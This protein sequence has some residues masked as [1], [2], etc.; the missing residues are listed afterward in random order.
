MDAGFEALIKQ[1]T[2]A[3]CR[4]DGQGV[5]ACFTGDGVYHDVFYGSF[6]GADIID[7][8]EAYFHR[9]GTDFRWD[10]HDPVALEGV[11]YARYVFS[12]ASKLE[13]HEGR[14]ACFE[15]VAICRLQDGLITDYRE[16]ANA[17]TG[18]SLIGFP[19]ARVAKFIAREAR[20]LLARDEAA[21]HRN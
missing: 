3:A 9:D 14:R 13:G 8:I 15:G 16:V 5:A 4:G 1:M 19:D 11:G 10:L 20:D 21:A 12:Y 6:Q 18:L 2:Q 17:A 7:L